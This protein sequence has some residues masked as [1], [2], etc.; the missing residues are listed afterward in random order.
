MARSTK[1]TNEMIIELLNDGEDLGYLVCTHIHNPSKNIMDD[2]LRDLWMEAKD[3]LIAIQNY[4][5]NYITDP[6][7]YEE[8][9]INNNESD[10]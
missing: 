10:Y 5:S 7:E 2:D 1:V 6:T 4:L 8:D 9:I 3:N